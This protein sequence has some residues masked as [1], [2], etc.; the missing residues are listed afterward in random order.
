MMQCNAIQFRVQVFE[1]MLY[2]VDLEANALLSCHKLDCASSLRVLQRASPNNPL[3]DVSVLTTYEYRNFTAY[4]LKLYM[5][6][7]LVLRFFVHF[8][9]RKH[10]TYSTVLM[11]YSIFSIMYLVLFC[12]E[13]TDNATSDASGR[14][15]QSA[16]H[17]STC[18]FRMAGSSLR[19]I[20]SPTG[21][22]GRYNL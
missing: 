12:C 6:F 13:A 3:R 2:V 18:V 7:A 9:D 1:D 21:A 10:A 11:L 20:K 8:F 15:S 22:R 19:P 17:V 16:P 5:Y 4:K 14:V